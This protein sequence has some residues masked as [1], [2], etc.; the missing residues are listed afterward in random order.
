VALGIVAYR[1]GGATAVGLMS[2]LR[3][4]PSAVVAPLAAPLADRG[5]RERVLVLVST[6]R[7]VT[8]GAAG[9]V[10]AIDGP[11][12][13][14]YVLAIL[15][16][17]IATLYLPA[18]SALLPS[19]CRT[20][21]ELASANVVRGFLD[22]VATLLGPLLA[23]VLLEFTG[24]LRCVR[25]RGR[26]LTGRGGHPS[27]IAVRGSAKTSCATSGSPGGRGGGGNTRHRA[28]P[29]PGATQRPSHRPDLHP[30]CADRLRGRYG[31]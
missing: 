29:R 6:F 17:V 2:L 23:A 16:T 30:W 3:M 13:I 5:R 14:V 28:K 1:D 26:C 19:L 22:S 20:G 15:A 9:V 10:V 8:I 18:H 21:H 11:V 4:V 24:V 27:R 31:I 25:C 12:L 7:G